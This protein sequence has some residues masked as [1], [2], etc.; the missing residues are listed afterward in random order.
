MCAL[1]S[2]APHFGRPLFG[3]G[4]S[5]SIVIRKALKNTGDANDLTRGGI[6]VPWFRMARNV[7]PN[8]AITAL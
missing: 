5:Q 7:F 4:K 2:S 3:I 1:V 6:A 8:G